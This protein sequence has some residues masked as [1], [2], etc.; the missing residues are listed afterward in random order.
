MWS[1]T[2]TLK[3]A[4]GAPTPRLR[5]KPDA[6]N[7]VPASDQRDFIVN[8][9]LL[10]VRTRKTPS[11]GGRILRCRERTHSLADRDDSRYG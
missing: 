6:R 7:N 4:L 10:T 2:Q 8:V 5:I 3:I 1:W 11:A 9:A